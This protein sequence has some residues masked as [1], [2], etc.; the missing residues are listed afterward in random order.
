MGHQILLSLA[1]A[2]SGRLFNDPIRLNVV[3]LRSGRQVAGVLDHTF[4]VAAGRNGQDEVGLAVLFPDVVDGDDVGVRAEASHGLGLAADT[5]AGGF[6]E[7]LGLHQ[8]ESHVAVKLGVV[9][10]VDLLLAALTQEAFHLVAAVGEGGV[11]A[12]STRRLRY[13]RFG[14]NSI[15]I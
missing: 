8:D 7:A 14:S 13:R 11:L 6:V 15:S 5:G 12:Q 10:E 4:H 9:G 3:P 1:Q 2:I